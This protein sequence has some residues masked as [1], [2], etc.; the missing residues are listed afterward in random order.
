M[1]AIYYYLLDFLSYRFAD[2][3]IFDTLSHQEYIIKKFKVPSSKQKIVLPVGVNLNL[4]ESF[5]ENNLRAKNKSDI[6]VMWYGHFTPLQGMEYIIKAAS[7]LRS[8]NRIH[9]TLIGSADTPGKD[10][11]E[12]IKH[13]SR[14][15]NLRNIT[16]I[17]NIAYDKLITYIK[18]ADICLGIFGNTAKAKRVIP[19]KVL[20]G[21]ACGRIVITARNIELERY[22]EDRADIIYCEPGDPSDL[23]EKIIYVADNLTDLKHIGENACRRIKDQFSKNAL[24]NILNNNL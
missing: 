5:K 20:D 9:F 24:I 11:E 16:F 4:I 6:N 10:W 13:Y 2:V 12:K 23:A 3:I 22:F 15:K 7:E 21:M 17:N 14:V 19:N 8:D 18:E 1:R